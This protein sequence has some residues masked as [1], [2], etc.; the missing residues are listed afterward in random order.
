M[1]QRCRNRAQHQNPRAWASLKI[2]G[3][4]CPCELRPLPPH[5]PGDQHARAEPATVRSWLT[6]EAICVTAKT[7]TRSRNSSR[8][9]AC[10][11]VSSLIAPLPVSSKPD[12]KSSGP[13]LF[14][15]DVTT[16]LVGEVEPELAESLIEIE[17]DR[18]L[19][20]SRPDGGVIRQAP[21]IGQ[22]SG[23]L[24]ALGDQQLEGFG[25]D[26]VPRHS[27]ASSGL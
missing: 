12:Q 22:P 4:P 14:I 26:V 17:R 21:H 9:V 5:Q 24:A 2:D 23:E 1:R 18:C 3:R 8:L 16:E 11:C 15:G 19:N 7:K 27:V 6:S 10:R 20:E 25:G 13:Q